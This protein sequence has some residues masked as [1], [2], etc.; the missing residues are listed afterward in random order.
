VTQPRWQ[1]LLIV[2]YVQFVHIPRTDSLYHCHGPRK[3]FIWL[4]SGSEYQKSW[5][6]QFIIGH[7]LVVTINFDIVTSS[8][9]L[10]SV[11]FIIYSS[12]SRISTEINRTRNDNSS[13]ENTFVF[14]VWL[15]A[16]LIAYVNVWRQQT[17]RHYS[18]QCWVFSSITQVVLAKMLLCNWKRH[19]EVSQMTVD[20]LKQKTTIDCTNV[21]FIV[22]YNFCYDFRCMLQASKHVMLWQVTKDF[23]V[24]GRWLA[25]RISSI[26]VISTWVYTE[27]LM[28][29]YVYNT[30]R[31][32]C[33]H[34]TDV[35]S[36][37]W[38]NTSH[39][40]W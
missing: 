24:W 35:H 3:P 4:R 19:D 18:G 2:V 40:C 12:V 1:L 15:C 25:T 10:S 38:E 27:T 7:V 34:V 37:Y 20:K 33:C 14:S 22:V 32:F 30:V 8:T 5:R 17:W 31:M 23:I 16:C 13:L 21:I 39:V 6:L 9:L 26:L 36:S 29:V 11:Q 28:V